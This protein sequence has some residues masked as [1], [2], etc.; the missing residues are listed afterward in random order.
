M[1]L[2]NLDSTEGES[3]VDKENSSENCTEDSSNT[4]KD[5]G[6]QTTDQSPTNSPSHALVEARDS[7]SSAKGKLKQLIPI[8]KIFVP[9]TLFWA[10]FFQRSS[11]WIVQ[12]THMDCYL[13]SL[14]VPPG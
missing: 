6:V 3:D 4:S 10:I 12:A 11:T 8:F 7:K 5:L 14:H 1:I 9:L 13:G 2:L